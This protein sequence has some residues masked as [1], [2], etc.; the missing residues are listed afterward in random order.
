[1]DTSKESTPPE[2]LKQ[3][4]SHAEGVG[5]VVGLTPA[6]SKRLVLKTDLVVLPQ[7]VL[8]MTLAFLDK[9]SRSVT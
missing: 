7:I 5:N 8:C 9:V 3:M 4:G 2:G 6:Q 1:M